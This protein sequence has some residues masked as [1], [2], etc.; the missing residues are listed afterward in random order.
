MSKMSAV[1]CRV[2]K[3]IAT[4]YTGI[5][6]GGIRIYSVYRYFGAVF[7]LVYHGRFFKGTRVLPE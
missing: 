3:G 5:E 1:Y 2:F 7:I 4:F 6:P